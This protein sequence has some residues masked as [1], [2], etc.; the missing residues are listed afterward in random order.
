MQKQIKLRQVVDQK[1]NA[2]VKHCGKNSSKLI[3][4]QV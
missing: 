1:H 3:K 2:P 4:K